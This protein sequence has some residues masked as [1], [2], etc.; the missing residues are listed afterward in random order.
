MHEASL[1]EFNSFLTLTYDEK[2]LPKDGSLDHRH[3]QLFMK[4][5]R[6][7]LYSEFGSELKIKFFMCGE[8]GE[9]FKRPHY[10]S[11]I[12]G[13]DFPDKLY[14]KTTKQGHVLY[15]SETLSALWGKG[16]CS[17]GAANYDTAGYVARYT[18]KKIN[19]PLAERSLHYWDIDYDTGEA[20]HRK[21]EYI[22]MSRGG[23][24]GEGIAAA[25][26]DKFAEDCF[27]SDRIDVKG[28]LV[29]PPKYYLDRLRK[30][31]PEAADKIQ[32]K[33]REAAKAAYQDNTEERL[34][35]RETVK[36]AQIKQLSRPYEEGST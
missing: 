1:H 26:Y 12:F 7:Y 13:H 10:H 35:V 11:L 25:W 15:T 17:L 9:Q 6:K 32:A 18:L 4:K 3:F 36:H 2:H 22:R 20:T 30:S 5:Y 19:G 27:P 8:Y 29:T 34:Q 23:R 33:R 14:L 24:T 21:P 31:D 16:I 28:K